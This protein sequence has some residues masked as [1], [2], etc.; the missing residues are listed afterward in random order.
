MTEQSTGT[1]GPV[2]L[3]EQKVPG[4]AVVSACLSPALLTVAWLVA[5]T[6]QPGGYD[7]VRQT[8]S[9]L[10]GQAGTDRWVMTSAL[11]LVGPCY[12]LTAAGL[13]C[14]RPSARVLLIVAG[15]CSVGIAT[16]PEPA[17]GPTALHLAWT[18]V[19]GVTIAVWPAFASRPGPGPGQRLPLS[20]RGCAVVT[21]MF[22]GMLGWVVIE[23]QGGSVLG[24][25]ERLTASV[26]TTWPLV[27]ALAL[28]RAARSE[29]AGVR[30]GPGGMEPDEADVVTSC[31]GG[32]AGLGDDP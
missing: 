19:G 30:T 28:R 4:W 23:T 13:A 32:G 1:L 26:Q 27:I 7:P 5:D 3:S 22:V 24:L 25:A 29:M 9:V 21:A 16:S 11:F 18:A 15:M 12:L 20:G 6:L 10:A 2:L 31:D 17:T 8:V 14:L